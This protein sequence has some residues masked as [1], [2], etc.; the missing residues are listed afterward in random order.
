[1]FHD[2]LNPSMLFSTLTLFRSRL[3]MP[4]L[5][6][7][8]AAALLTLT[9]HAQT[10]EAAPPAPAPAASSAPPATASAAPAPAPARYTASN[11]ALA[12]NFMDANHDGRISR[13]EAASFSGVAKHFDEAD[14][15]HD[16][17][18]S[19]EEFDYAMNYV[20]PN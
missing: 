1:M 11:L 14:T 12:F 15:N 13:E 3:T 10:P 2:D 5:F 6:A 4:S 20:K 18:L 17:A 16:N 7:A 19:R 9:A 8:T